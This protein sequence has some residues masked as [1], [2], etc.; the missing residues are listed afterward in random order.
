MRRSKSAGFLPYG[1]REVLLWQRFDLNSEDEKVISFLAERSFMDVTLLADYQLVIAHEQEIKDPNNQYLPKKLF[2]NW[3]SIP[4]RK[5]QGPPELEKASARRPERQ[6]FVG[7]CYQAGVRIVTALCPGL[8]L[9]CPVSDFIMIPDVERSWDEPLIFCR[10][11]ITSAE[12]SEERRIL[13]QLKPES[14]QI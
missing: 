2:E 13:A 9:F 12:Q 6:Q 1:K 8:G 10:P 11:T 4:R 7:L 14:L 5:F 3:K